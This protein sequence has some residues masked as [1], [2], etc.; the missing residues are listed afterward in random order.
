[1][2][3]YVCLICKLTGHKAALSLPEKLLCFFYSTCH[4]LFALG[5]NNLRTVGFEEISALY[6]AE[7]SLW[8]GG[9]DGVKR[10][11][12]ETGQVIDYVAEDLE[13]IYEDPEDW[14][15]VSQH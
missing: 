13:L 9:R 10:L 15:S 12:P 3:L 14:K 8:V 7:D 6:L 4:T 2:S 5:K 11:D 1:M